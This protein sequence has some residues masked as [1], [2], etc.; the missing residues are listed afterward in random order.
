MG[1]PISF[2]LGLGL[3][4]AEAVATSAKKEEMRLYNES[5][6]RDNYIGAA[7]QQMLE[8]EVK[9]G[10][11]SGKN[12]GGF[13][14]QRLISDLIDAVGYRYDEA[15]NEA[16]ILICKY[17]VETMTDKNYSRYNTTREYHNHCVCCDTIINL[18][19]YRCED[20]GRRVEFDKELDRV[21]ISFLKEPFYDN[22]TEY[23]LERQIWLQGWHWG[24]KRDGYMVGYGILTCEE[25]PDWYEN[26]MELVN[27]WKKELGVED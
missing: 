15:R 8:R 27:R 23:P 5:K 9:S 25:Y 26:H 16:T 14:V 10:I 3:L 7:T 22:L 6:R 11:V 21:T 4:G 18:G 19:D 1:G 12:M 2:L 13:E 17:L 24:E 20:W